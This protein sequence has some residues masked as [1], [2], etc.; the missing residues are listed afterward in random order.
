MTVAQ[1]SAT[2]YEIAKCGDPFALA[3]WTA[4]RQY[5]QINVTGGKWIH[6]M[7]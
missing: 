2:P 5:H 7:V 6:N 3:V 4:F 1:F